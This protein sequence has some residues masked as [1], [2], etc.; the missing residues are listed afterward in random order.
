[1][2]K[3]KGLFSNAI[4]NILTVSF[5]AIAGFIIVPIIIKGIGSENFGIY[6]IILMIGGFAQLQSM[7]LGEATLKYVAQYYSRND[8]IG[9]NRVLGATLTVYIFSGIIISGIIITFSSYIVSLFKISTEN[10][11]SAIIAMRIAGLAFTF[12]TFSGALKTIP[13]ATQRYDVLN[14]YRLTMMV[15]RYTA[16]YLIAKLGGGIIGLTYLVLGSACID[17]IIFNFLAVY[18][19]PGIR[20]YPNFEKSGIKE[21]FGYGI[22]SFINDLIQ[23]AALY[24]DQLILGMF[25]SA[26]SVAYLTAPKDLITKAQG[27]TG[28]AGQALFPRFSSMDE[29][30][31]MQNLYIT[32]LWV[33]TI[34][35]VVIFIPL[36]VVIPSFLAKWLSPEFAQNSST[37]ARLFS[38]GIALNGGVTA[39][40]ALLKGTGRIRWLTNIISTLTLFSGIITAILVYKFGLIGSGIRVLMFSWIGI[41]LCLVVGRKVFPGFPILRVLFETV[42]IP[43]LISAIVFYF[44]I[45]LIKVSNIFSWVGIIITY[46]AL[47]GIMIILQFSANWLIYQGNG[48][49]TKVI[50]DLYKKVIDR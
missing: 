50:I 9:V 47:A 27:L 12:N 38:L 13:E 48:K 21:V 46:S 22:Y 7:G 45:M 24:V 8:I 16:M 28:A 26:S 23:K 14:K 39:Y 18:L 15:L 34:F 3:S 41:T 25:F 2:V 29:G 44:G 43:L 20:C 4:W 10:L 6:T 11:A 19:I 33:L 5:T 1:V 35:S 40:F 36:A 42:I 30:N 37:F 17:I 49:G 31:E 32:S